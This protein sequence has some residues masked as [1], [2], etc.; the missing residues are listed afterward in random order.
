MSYCPG[1]R[2]LASNL[3]LSGG[4]LWRNPLVEVDG[5]G[6]IVRVD[7]DVERV[8]SSVMTEFYSGLMVAGFV[9]AHSHLE[10]SYLRG[11]IEP[12]CGFAGFASQIGAIRG[13]YSD[14]ERHRALRQGA[15]EMEREGIVAV[16][17]IVNGESSYMVK[18][19]GGGSGSDSGIRY[20]NFAELF[21][22]GCSDMGAIESLLRHESTTAT[23]HSLYSLNDPILRDI[24]AHGGGD[25]G[26]LSIHFMESES[27]QQLYDGVGS[28]H[29]WYSRM[30]FECDFLGYGSPAERL[31]ALVPADRSVMLVHNCYVTQRDIDLI[32]SHFRAP[33]YWVLCPRSNRYIS[34]IKSPHEILRRNGLRICV[35]SD[36]L[37]SNWGLSMLDELREMRGVPLLES[38]DW[39][40][41]VGAA[42][43]GFSGLGD[44]KVG[45][46]PG[47]NVIAGLDYDGFA[48]TQNSKVTRII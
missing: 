9:N 25:G 43:L 6:T 24:V 4:Q 44:I 15:M 26:V 37:A 17:D 16:G 11:A 22:L 32:M 8:D 13:R 20:R 14:D 38:L 28:L 34:G 48:L 2:R 18:G 10:L 12:G 39:A 40:T 23:P 42:A 29:D 33:I 19:R 41:R 47:I 1:H 3:L 45:Y 36:S 7:V 30:G 5:D 27:E 35:G 46:R 31:V 21:G